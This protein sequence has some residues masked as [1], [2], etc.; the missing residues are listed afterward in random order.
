[1]PVISLKGGARVCTTGTLE[2]R[3]LIWRIA[4]L[5]A[6]LILSDLGFALCDCDEWKS[7]AIERAAH[8]VLHAEIY[9]TD[10]LRYE[11]D[12][13]GAIRAAWSDRGAE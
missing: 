9:L 5:Q 7:P 13:A 3:S 1:M 11:V 2:R 12:R 10:R 8:Q 4:D 6:R